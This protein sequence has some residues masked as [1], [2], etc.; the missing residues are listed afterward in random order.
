MLVP[1]YVR[2]ATDS[3]PNNSNTYYQGAKRYFK[4]STNSNSEPCG[5]RNPKS[6]VCIGRIFSC[7]LKRN[8]L[9]SLST[10]SLIR[11][12]H[13]YTN[14]RCRAAS[15]RLSWPVEARPKSTTPAIKTIDTPQI[16]RPR[17]DPLSVL[18]VCSLVGPVYE[19]QTEPNLDLK[20]SASPLLPRKFS[21]VLSVRWVCEI[22]VLI[23]RARVIDPHAERS[24]CLLRRVLPGRF[25]CLINFRFQ[26]ETRS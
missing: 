11:F 6:T 25:P 9:Q 15:Y 4:S 2:S 17:R 22:T 14:I 13:T 23:T 8:L 12:T 26:R 24:V 7:L 10:T 18:D 16:W 20:Y 3:H 21:G 1:A 5:T 19:I